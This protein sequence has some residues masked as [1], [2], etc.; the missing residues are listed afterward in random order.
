MSVCICVCAHVTSAPDRER[1]SLMRSLICR[2]VTQA[3][4]AA[5]DNFSHVLSG[6]SGGWG[7]G[8][9]KHR[10]SPTI[11]LPEKCQ[12]ICGVKMGCG[13]SHSDTHRNKDEMSHR[14]GNHCYKY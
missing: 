7:G 11:Q 14:C 8:G 12:Q 9:S 10:Q 13:S 1:P 3:T 6:G 4:D 2:R 5:E